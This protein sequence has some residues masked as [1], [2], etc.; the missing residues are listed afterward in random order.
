MKYGI[1]KNLCR[2]VLQ[3]DDSKVTLFKYKITTRNAFACKSFFSKLVTASVGPSKNYASD[4]DPAVPI[5]RH[6]STSKK[7]SR[8]KINDGKW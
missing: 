7:I 4:A 3:F 6:S 2:E 1:A 8:I 5:P